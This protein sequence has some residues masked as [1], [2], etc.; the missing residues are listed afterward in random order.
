MNQPSA[1]NIRDPLLK[2]LGASSS[3]KAGESV[4][5][6]N[7]VLFVCQDLDILETSFGVD[8]S[9]H[10]PKVRLWVGQAFRQ[11]RLHGYTQSEK[12]G[13]WA[14]TERGVVTATLLCSGAPVPVDEDP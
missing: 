11:L 6:R 8:A 4:S 3:F 5:V 9:T 1:K 13:L 2:V 14:L 12:N 7:V 10:I